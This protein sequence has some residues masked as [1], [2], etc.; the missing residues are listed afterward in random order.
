MK[1]LNIGIIGF[2]LRARGV[3]AVLSGLEMGAKIN[4]T[5]ISDPKNKEELIAEGDKSKID[6]SE[7]HFYKNE[8]DMLQNENLDGVIIGT[9]CSLHTKLA[10]K[11]MKKGIPLFLE[12]PVS[13]TYEDWQLL[14]EANQKYKCEVV[15][16][17]PLRVTPIVS[18]A[19]RLIDN[20][21]IGTIQHVSAVNYATYG[22]D[23]YHSWYRDENE[24]GGLFLQKAT[25][26]LDYINYIIGQKPVEICAM[27]SKQIMKGDKPAGLKCA[28][29]E[30]RYTCK[31]GPF[32]TRKI[33]GDYIHGDY[34]CFAVDTG[35]ED[36]GT[37]LVR[38]ESGMHAVYTQ[39]FFVRNKKAAKRSAI[40]AGDMGVLEF[41]FR[42][43]DIYIRKNYLPGEMKYHVELEG[44][45]YGGDLRLMINFTNIMLNKEKSETPLSEGLLSA[46]M[47]LKAK[48]SAETKQFV[49]LDDLNN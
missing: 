44:N 6:M 27:H 14:K 11:V 16:S 42:T 40:F 34:C 38:Y 17:F 25:H 32:H 37:A 30:E 10:I 36:S 23:Y 46:Y 48:E 33:N 5:A 3:F 13:T 41:D 35:N 21:E 15:V 43:K 29:C 49:K 47:C 45:H 7:T 28:D 9:R 31:E 26:D 4:L 19:K 8:D 2:G 39:N 20:G 24:T 18:E 22:G 1:E 12:K